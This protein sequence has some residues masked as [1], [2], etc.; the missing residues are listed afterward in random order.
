LA[1][2]KGFVAVLSISGSVETDSAA[3]EQFGD[4]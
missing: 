3:D 4:K 2:L 1:A